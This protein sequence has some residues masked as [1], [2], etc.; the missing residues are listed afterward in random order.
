MFTH[1]LFS[2]IIFSSPDM[3]AQYSVQDIE[4]KYYADGEDAYACRKT[5]Q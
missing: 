3:I 2:S 1:D 4:K 5:L